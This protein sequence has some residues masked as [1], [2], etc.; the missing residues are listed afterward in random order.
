MCQAGPSGEDGKN[1]NSEEDAEA[2]GE[3]RAP[4]AWILTAKPV[5][6]TGFAPQVVDS[7]LR[8]GT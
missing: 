5:L 2:V 1:E 6:S 4:S 7:S 8:T 3:K